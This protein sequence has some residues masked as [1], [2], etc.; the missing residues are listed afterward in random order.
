MNCSWRRLKVVKKMNDRIEIVIIGASIID[1]L[2]RPASEEVFR[3]GSYA[4]EEIRMS[5]GADALNEATLLSRMGKKVRLE[6][7]IGDDQAGKFLMEH[8][9]ENGIEVPEG[10]CRK[11]LTT[12]INVVLVREDGSRSFLTNPS[13]SLRSLCLSDICMDFPDSAKI[14][15]FASIFVFPKMGV[16]EMEMLFRRVKEQG[17]TL[18]ADMTK[19][20]N[21]E[22]AAELA[23]AF[24]YIDYLLPND[25]EVMLLT[26]KKNVEDAA[27]ALCDVGVGTVIVKCGKRGCYIHSRVE[28]ASGWIPAAPDVKCIDTTGAG[29][30]FVA[31]FLYALSEGRTLWECA[32]YANACGGRAVEVMGATEFEILMDHTGQHQ[33]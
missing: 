31:G 4:V 6:T 12:G 29:D 21:H 7:V 27:E 9:R 19:C 20:K 14:V 1:I 33:Q 28:K 18:C 5:T 22:T 30:S 11:D 26:G 2:V 24:K 13:G 32:L 16:C 3:A 15:C 10:C 17:K 23:P 25:E 8:F